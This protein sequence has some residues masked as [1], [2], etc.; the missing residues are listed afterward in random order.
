QYDP[1][2]KPQN[3]QSYEFGVDLKFF[4]NRVGVDYTFS[5]QDV[6]D[7]IFAV[8]LAGSTGASSLVMNGGAVQTKAHE[9]M[10]YITPVKRA[11]F[12]WDMN[13]NFAAVNNKV[14]ELAEGVESIFLGGF[15]TPQVRAGV[16]NTYPVIYGSQFA[17]NEFGQILVDE[18]PNSASYGM[19][20]PGE[21][22][23]LGEITPDFIIGATTNFNYKA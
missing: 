6:T 17:R 14:L 20:M 19:P 1:N 22:G 5:Q 12:Q 11:D 2:L 8:P 21:P 10:L 4:N 3:T 9:V 15:T 7:Q 23:V 16:G 13:F 18:D